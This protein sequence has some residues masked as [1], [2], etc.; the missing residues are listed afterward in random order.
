M[1]NEVPR[2]MHWKSTE[3][4]TTL[5]G[6]DRDV[7]GQRTVISASTCALGYGA[8]FICLLVSQWYM[9]RVR[10]QLIAQSRHLLSTNAKRSGALVR[11]LHALV[12]PW[13]QVRE[14]RSLAKPPGDVAAGLRR[15]RFAAGL[16]YAI[17]V[18][19]FALPFFLPAVCE[20]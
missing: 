13:L 7:H 4:S 10:S 8:V 11:A 19:V 1:T 18:L 16:S 2:P 12:R 5:G 14:L 20:R 6:A 17:A 15:Y 9:V 3:R